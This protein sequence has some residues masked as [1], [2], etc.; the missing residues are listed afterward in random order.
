M[1]RYLASSGT[2]WRIAGE[3]SRWTK[4]TRRETDPSPLIIRSFLEDLPWARKQVTTPLFQACPNRI[5]WKTH[6]VC[7]ERKSLIIMC[8]VYI[9]W[10]FGSR[11]IFSLYYSFSK[12]GHNLFQSLSNLSSVFYSPNIQRYAPIASSY[13]LIFVRKDWVMNDTE[14]H[15]SDWEN[16]CKRYDLFS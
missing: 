11:L 3:D 6:Y 15:W 5:G 10:I 14:K 2:A 13:I 8:S 12:L 9:L 1:F 4:R 16:T 7:I